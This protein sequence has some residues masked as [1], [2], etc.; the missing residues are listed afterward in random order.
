MIGTLK[1]KQACFVACITGFLHDNGST[2]SQSEI[3]AELS[4]A[5]LCNDQGVVDLGK[6]PDACDKLG[7]VLLEITYRYPQ[8]GE[9][10]DGSLLIT[11]NGKQLHSLRFH[12]WVSDEKLELMNPDTGKLELWNKSL[13]E[14]ES[15][16]LFRM[17]IQSST[18][19]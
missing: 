16:K 12:R 19:K 18:G 10:E 3:L 14:A 6:E 17:H 2:K 11:F 8:Q 1:E 9:F 5:G 7:V 13:I 4:A 15:P